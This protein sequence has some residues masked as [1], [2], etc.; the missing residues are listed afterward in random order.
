MKIFVASLPF[1]LEE[2]DIKETFE[3][4][5]EVSSVKL[6]LDKETGRKKGFGF[7]EMPDD[8]QAKKAILDLNGLEIFGRA[9]A[10]TQAEE[11]PNGGRKGGFGGGDRG[12]YNKGGY[13]KG[14]RD[15]GSY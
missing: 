4:Y 1:K 6:V 13:Q 9:I 11:K 2:S 10:V 5:G 15:S 8:E 14:G 12:S 7:V 3:E